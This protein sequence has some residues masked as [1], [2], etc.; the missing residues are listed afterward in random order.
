MAIS[1]RQGGLLIFCMLDLYETHTHRFVVNINMLTT[2]ISEKY[3]HKHITYY[4]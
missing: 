2:I 1:V 3:A 4:F